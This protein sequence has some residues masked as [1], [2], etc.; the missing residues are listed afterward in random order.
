MVWILTAL[1]GVT[2]PT[3][4]AACMKIERLQAELRDEQ[5]RHAVCHATVDKVLRDRLGEGAA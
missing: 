4:F 1:L 2:V 5:D 3:L